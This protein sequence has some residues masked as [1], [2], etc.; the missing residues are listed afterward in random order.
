MSPQLLGGV[1][2]LVA[3]VLSSAAVPLLFAAD[4]DL[5]PTFGVGGIADINTLLGHSP[6]LDIQAN[7]IALDGSGRIVVAGSAQH[8]NAGGDPQDDSFLVFRLTPEGALDT[9]FAADYGGY[10]LA[11]FDLDGIG[12]F[13]YDAARDVAIQAD[14]KIVAAGFAY[15]NGSDTQFAVMRVDDAGNLDATFN[16]SGTAHFGY[17]NGNVIQALRIDAEG[18]IVLAGGTSYRTG[19]AE[20]Q[21][22]AAVTRLTAQGLI[23]PMFGAVR[24]FSFSDPPE[25]A[26]SSGAESLAIDDSGNIVVAGGYYTNLVSAAAVRR[27]TSA[28]AMDPAFAAGAP[29]GIPAPAYAAG[30]IYVRADGSF[31]VGG[32]GLDGGNGS[33]YVSKFLQDGTPDDS[34]GSNG[35]ASLPMPDYGVIDFIAPTKRGGWLLAGSYWGQGTLLVKVLGDGQPDTTLAGTGYMVVYYPPNDAQTT[36][37]LFQMGKP[38]MT[39]DG[40]LIVAGTTPEEGTNGDGNVAVMRILAD[41]DAVFVG[42]FEAGQ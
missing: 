2:F 18:R 23:D 39:A 5:D 10:R 20:Y 16:G 35:T 32:F 27:L 26:V 4:G 15:S 11:A 28:G 41:Y 36:G 40:K 14:G 17:A 6:P 38:V 37:S 12:G 19:P 22:Y 25:L 24:E 33:V 31:V 9:T 29:A 3:L 8:L 42:G 34:F 21:S 1:R 13:G 7:A 30:A